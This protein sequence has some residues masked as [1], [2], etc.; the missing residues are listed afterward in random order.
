M[1]RSP[2]QSQFV[3]PGQGVC[4]GVA[5][6]AGAQAA[7]WQREECGIGNGRSGDGAGDPQEC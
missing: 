7:Q 2:S 1:T 3:V 6:L 4:R 5:A